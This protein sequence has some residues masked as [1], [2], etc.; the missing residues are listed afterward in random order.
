MTKNA[1]SEKKDPSS[2]SWEYTEVMQEL[3]WQSSRKKVEIQ[4]GDQIYTIKNPFRKD[5]YGLSYDLADQIYDSIRESETDI[6]DIA[7]NLGFKVDN[8]KNIK[9][10]VFYN[11]HC[12][13]RYEPIE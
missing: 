8:I 4:F 5:A 2:G 10:H 12:L 6:C 1:G 9:D 11:K 13:D 7:Q 3:D